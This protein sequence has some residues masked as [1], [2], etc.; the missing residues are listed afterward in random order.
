MKASERTVRLLDITCDERDYPVVAATGDD[1]LGVLCLRLE[2]TPSTNTVNIRLASSAEAY[3]IARAATALG[4]FLRVREAA[5]TVQSALGVH[6]G[7]EAGVY[8]LP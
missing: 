2:P 6:R 8:A 7:Q 4:D 3:S 1:V 5:L